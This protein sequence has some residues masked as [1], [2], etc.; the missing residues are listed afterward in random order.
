MKNILYPM[1]FIPKQNCEEKAEIFYMK[2]PEKWVVKLTAVYKMI[3]G[4]RIRNLPVESLNSVI[5]MIF[6]E[7]VKTEKKAFVPGNNWLISTEPVNTN[8]LLNVVYSWINHEFLERTKDEMLRDKILEVNGKLDQNDLVWERKEVFLFQER[9]NFNRTVE[10]QSE[11]FDAIPEYIC[12]RLCNKDIIFTLNG[13]PLKFKRCRKNEMMAWPAL[14]YK[15]G[16]EKNWYY[17]VVINFS[18]QTIPFSNTPYILMNV[19][20]R[21]LASQPLIGKLPY[22][23]NVTVL[24]SSKT[25]WYNNREMSGFTT[26]KIKYDKKAQ[27]KVSWKS[28]AHKILDDLSLGIQVPE[29]NELI[30]DPETYLNSEKLN[31]AII[32]SNSFTKYKHPV[33]SGMGMKDMRELY[34]QVAGFMPELQK[35]GAVEKVNLRMKRNLLMGSPD[36]VDLADRLN[37]LSKIIG[38]EMKIE[39]RYDTDIIKDALKAAMERILGIKADSNDVQHIEKDGF[40]LNLEYSQIGRLADRLDGQKRF[41]DRVKDIESSV[42]NATIPTGCIIE[43]KGKDAWNSG[44]DPKGALRTG[45]ARTSRLTQFITPESENSDGKTTN[46]KSRAENAVWDLLR[47][48]GYLPCPPS[49]GFKKSKVDEEVLLFGIWVLNKNAS[50]YRNAIRFP[51]V[52]Y[53]NTKSTDILL[54]CPLFDKWLPY[55]QGQIEICKKVNLEEKGIF[56]MNPDNIARYIRKV[57]MEASSAKNAVILMDSINIRRY[58]RW[59]ADKNI[60]KDRIWV[61]DRNN[62]LKTSTVSGLRIIRV[63]HDGEVPE[64]FAC[65]QNGVKESFASGLFRVS[66]SVFWSIAKKP[67]MLLR[68]FPR[69]SKLDK[70]LNEFKYPGI[71]EITPVILREEDKTEEWAYAI[72]K[73]REM[74]SYYDE[75]VALPVPLHL[76][77]KLEQ[78]IYQVK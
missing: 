39:V 47:Q 72:H 38:P 67:K 3:Y 27:G 21:K 40:S 57:L 73:L 48:F 1:V 43:L 49:L 45:F 76:A 6:T 70:P 63:R 37:S 52:V 32:L 44:E 64:Y 75:V 51:V 18:V 71:T 69:D 65:D 11:Y 12:N 8:I 22:D 30:A 17:T 34:D 16:K 26:A 59:A 23:N 24:L 61:D 77:K 78:Y 2:F 50:D 55:S 20:T 41:A 74:L 46:L 29:L 35:L 28:T 25:Y 60:Q 33:G 15:T 56:F 14:I 10:L 31:A 42:G 62:E 13:R 66:E 36:K 68:V 4:N 9:Q 58:W 7:I 5:E 19:S 54:K 53:M